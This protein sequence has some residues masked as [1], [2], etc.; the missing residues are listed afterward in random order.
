MA[1]NKKSQHTQ[2]MQR[3]R[4]A[5]IKIIEPNWL[6]KSARLKVKTEGWIIATQT[7]LIKNYWANRKNGS[8]PLWRLCKQ[9]A[10][11]IDHLES[12]WPILTRIEYLKK[13]Y[14]RIGHY[15]IHWKI[16]KYYGILKCEK[17]YKQKP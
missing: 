13:R 2:Y 6:L 17:W 7:L 9:K 11:S 16:C 15:Y 5:N 4:N 8:I 14:G 10:K 3:I 1:G 12:S